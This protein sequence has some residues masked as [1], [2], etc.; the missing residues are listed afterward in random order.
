MRRIGRVAPDTEILRSA[1][2]TNREIVAM[3]A[4][5]PRGGDRPVEAFPLTGNPPKYIH[6]DTLVGIR[7]E[8]FGDPQ[9]FVAFH[10]KNCRSRALSCTVA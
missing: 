6:A 7:A 10:S 9:E 2:A 8:L 4:R 5:Y 1:H 3:V